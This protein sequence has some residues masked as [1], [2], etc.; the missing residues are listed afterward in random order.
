MNVER[1][2]HLEK[3]LRRDLPKQ[4]QEFNIGVFV[5]KTP[6]G[7]CGFA[8]CAIGTAAFDPIF[9]SQGLF[10]D[11]ADGIIRF[12]GSS[13]GRYDEWAAACEFF[14]ITEELANTLF[15]GFYYKQHYFFIK[16]VTKENVADRIRMLLDFGESFVLKKYYHSVGQ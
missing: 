10:Y 1:L 6:E 7:E 12:S 15:N 9:N 3:I 8:A 14:D 13:S 4:V 5:S 11:E 16:D 2:E